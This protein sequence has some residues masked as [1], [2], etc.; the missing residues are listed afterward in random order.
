MRQLLLR[1]GGNTVEDAAS[2]QAGEAEARRISGLPWLEMMDAFADDLPATVDEYEKLERDCA[3]EG[4]DARAVRLLVEHEVVS[5]AFA[6]CELDRNSRTS[7]EPVL[8]LLKAP[9]P[10]LLDPPHPKPNPGLRSPQ[11]GRR[12]GIQAEIEPTR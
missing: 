4:E 10:N 8:A 1:H 9:P 7:I 11:L 2:R 12:S 5:L 6:R 3:F